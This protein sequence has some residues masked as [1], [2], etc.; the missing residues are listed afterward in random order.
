[1]GKPSCDY[2]AAL[3]RLLAA[4]PFPGNIREMESM[5]FDAVSA[6]NGKTLS[7]ARFHEWI[8]TDSTTGPEKNQLEKNVL[9]ETALFADMASLPTLQE[10]AGMLV[11]EAMRRADNNQSV[12]SRFLGI[13]QPALS[14]RIKNLEKKEA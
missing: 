10:A 2:P 5:V 4:Y 8:G 14:K 3:P 13:S 11:R 6:H 12:A 9:N 7:L 1:M